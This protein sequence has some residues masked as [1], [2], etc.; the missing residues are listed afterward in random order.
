MARGTRCVWFNF[1]PNSFIEI[2]VFFHSLFLSLEPNTPSGV[3]GCEGRVNGESNIEKSD[4][5]LEVRR[6]LPLIL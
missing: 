6:S 4:F 1:N 2:Y 3:R 5:Y